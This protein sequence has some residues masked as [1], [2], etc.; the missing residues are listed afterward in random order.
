MTNGPMTSAQLPKRPRLR[1]YLR[2]LVMSPDRMLVK[3]GTNTVILRGSSVEDVAS[4]VLPSLDGSRTVEELVKAFDEI[5]RSVL[6]G[7]L[8]LFAAQGLLEDDASRSSG[9]LDGQTLRYRRQ[10]TYWLSI[11]GE[12]YAIQERLATAR[13]ALFGLGGVG[14]A[15][16]TSLT[17]AGVG[18]LIL[19]DSTPVVAE[20]ELFG[21]AGEDVGQPRS[22]QMGVRL[23]QE[24]T[25]VTVETPDIGT[26]PDAV[27]AC[28]ADSDLGVY[29]SDSSSTSA[30]E[31]GSL[32]ICTALNTASLDLGIPWTRAVVDHHR[33]VVGPSVLPKET[34]CLTCLQLR[35]RSNLSYNQDA[36][37]YEE[38]RGEPGPADPAVL[39]PFVSLTANYATIEVL[40]LLTNFA[41]PV[42]AGAFVALNSLTGETTRHEVLR[43]PRCP[44]C[45][46]TRNRPQMKIWDLQD[47]P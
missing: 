9:V 29:C 23:R 4:V 10:T 22:Q 8:E 38:H 6:I 44:D 30:M 13:V 39:A 42:T 33:G 3:G 18:Q 35:L 28:L 27:A 24:S 36:L 31:P 12:R 1:P 16:A 43:L 17:T 7:A 41:R 46:P 25:A 20:D 34:A 15:L 40:K 32:E 14:A 5:D 26:S 37:A 47:S 19:V 2:T 11:A 21:Y 45:G